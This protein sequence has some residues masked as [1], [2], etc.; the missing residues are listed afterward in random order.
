M[1]VYNILIECSNIIVALDVRPTMIIVL[2]LL[3]HLIWWKQL[4]E[5]GT[6]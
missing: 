1:Q 5:K 3:K 2:I 4:K 6:Y